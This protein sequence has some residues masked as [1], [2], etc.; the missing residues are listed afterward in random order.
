MTL[1]GRP[2]HPLLRTLALMLI[3]ITRRRPI[4]PAYDFSKASRQGIGDEIMLRKTGLGCLVAAALTFPALP[5]QAHCG[6]CHHKC[7][8]T[9][10]TKTVACE[11]KCVKGDL[12]HLRASVD[13]N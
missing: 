8:R 10:E 12:E 2:F 5:V 9:C 3:D 11:T 4:R 13:C 7:E 6:K 1:I